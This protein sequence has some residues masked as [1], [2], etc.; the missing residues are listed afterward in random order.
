ML[1]KCLGMVAG[2]LLFGL[3]ACSEMFHFS[4][5]TDESGVVLGE[6]NSSSV[7]FPGTLSSSSI[8]SAGSFVM[9]GNTSIDD[10]CSF[11]II[12]NLW[13]GPEGLMQVETGLGNDTETYGYWFSLE[14][15]G[16]T[17]RS[18]VVWPA[19]KGNEYSD[20][21]LDAIHEFCSGICAELDFE[22][23][24]FAG[25]GFNV[26][27]EASVFG[28]ALASGDASSWGGVCVTYA[29]ESD[30]DVVMSSGEQVY[31][32]RVPSMPKVTLPRSLNVTTRCVEWSR[33]VT[34]TGFA[35]DP[36]RIV[37]L[38]FVTYGE[39]GT[40][41]RFNIVGLGRYQQLFNSECSVQEN[42]A[43]RK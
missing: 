14:N 8:E 30:M 3:V 16:K 5:I 18:R 13:Y 19:E 31:V 24:G 25:V 35:G 4:E 38:L 1:N 43:S 41:S 6:K 7:I 32:N 21:A 22:S 27:G 11:S 9:N 34:T 39:N 12:D 29:S 2:S 15:T 37:S 28:N 20:D 33:F 26:V 10:A 17:E 42:F 40:Q 36:S 23:A